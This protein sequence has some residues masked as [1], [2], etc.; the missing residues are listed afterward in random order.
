[1]ANKFDSNNFESSEPSTI[2]AGD[3][4]G[5]KRTDLGTDYPPAT[6]ALKYT[7]RKLTDP[8]VV[9]NITAG[10]SGSDYIVSIPAA[11]S[12]TY[13]PGVYAW[14][15]FI[16]RTADSER[17]TVGY[18]V[19]TVAADTAAD[20][21]TDQRS[22][23]RRALDAVEAVLEKRAT[24]DQEEYSIAGRSLKHTPLPDL[25]VLRDKLK[26]EVRAEELAEQI[27]KGIAP[28]N[29]IRVRL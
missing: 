22:F 1:M 23:A 9:I 20:Q 11:T 12:A 4:T 28:A 18:G 21:T 8:T 25:I 15:A 17:V 3:F 2:K 29:V 5:W 19:W 10:E 26:A 27:K 16:E 7:A 6:H 14:Q 13:A 24:T